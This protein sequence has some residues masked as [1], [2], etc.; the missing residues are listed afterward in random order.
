MSSFSVKVG[1]FVGVAR[2]IRDPSH[3]REGVGIGGT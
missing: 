3:L 2:R 1:A